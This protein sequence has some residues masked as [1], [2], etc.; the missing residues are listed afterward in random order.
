MTDTCLRFVHTIPGDGHRN[1]RH[2]TEAHILAGSRTNV[3][4]CASLLTTPGCHFLCIITDKPAHSPSPSPTPEHFSIS[5]GASTMLAAVV[6]LD[7]PVLREGNDAGAGA[8]E[9]ATE[10]D[11]E[12][13]AATF[14]TELNFVNSR[15]L[16]VEDT[17]GGTSP[18]LHP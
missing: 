3:E 7:L 6:R 15:T 1:D 13:G 12:S 18:L 11:A 10:A 5:P 9:A 4:E 14:G 2:R 16:L 17:A 8:S